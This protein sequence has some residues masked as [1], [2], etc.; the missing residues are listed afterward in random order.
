MPI[1]AKRYEPE[2]IERSAF[3]AFL[4]DFQGLLIMS[5][6]SLIIGLSRPWFDLYVGSVI[7]TETTV[8]G[9]PAITTPSS[10]HEISLKEFEKSYQIVTVIDARPRSSFNKGRVPGSISIPKNQFETAF[11]AARDRLEQNASQVIIVYCSNSSCKDADEI[12]ENMVFYGY[13]NVS[14]FRGGWKEWQRA[15][16]PIEK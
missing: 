4:R 16:L 11:S 8:R 10:I 6:I 14:I 13:I 7:S 1:I 5:L 15:K 3:H 9:E 12:C 2:L